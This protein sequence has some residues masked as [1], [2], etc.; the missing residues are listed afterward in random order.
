MKKIFSFFYLIALFPF[1]VFGQLH[2]VWQ[3]GKKNGSS[4]DFALAPNGYKEFVAE[5][6][7]Q[8]TIFNI[9]FSNPKKS[10]P[11]ILPGPSDDWAG[12][13]Y[14]SGYYPRH[15]SRIVFGLSDVP[16][17]NSTHLVLN[18]VDANEKTPPKVSISINGHKTSI[19]LEKGVGKAIYGNDKKGEPQTKEIEVPSKWLKK[20]LNTIEVGAIKG[21]W[22]VYDNIIFKS[23]KPLKLLP[24][25]NSLIYGVKL[26]DFESKEN[27]EYRQPILVDIYQLE[28][29][30][31]LTFKVNNQNI[32]SKKVEKGHS[33]IEIF[34]PATAKPNKKIDFQVF[35][36]TQLIYHKV[37]SQNPER[38]LKLYQYVDLLMGTGNSR[39]MFKPG[40]SLPLS[41]VQIAPDNQDEIWKGGYE[42]TVENIMGFSHFSD[43]TMCG[44]LTMPTGGKLQVN[45]G[46]EENPDAGYRSR[47]DKKT[48]SAKIG[49][50]SVYL[51][52]TKIKAEI[53]ST[54]R[55]SLQ[56]Y[57]FPKM[58]SARILVDLFTPSEYP[59]NLV[60]AKVLKTTNNEIVGEA[61]YYNAFTG[62]SLQQYYTI[63]FVM[64]FSKPF[65]NMGGWVNNSVEEVKNYIPYWDRKHVFNTDAEIFRQIDS[66]K[67]K[68]DLGV[69]LNFR[70]ENN[71][72]ILV[73]T[74]VSLVDVKGARN[75][76]QQEIITPFAWNFDAVVKNAENIW[77]EYLGRIQIETDDY[78]EKV[79][80]YTNMYRAL[81][82]K[83]IWNDEDGRYRD[84]NEVIKTLGDKHDNIISGEYWNTFWNNQQLFNLIA[85]EISSQWAKSA[86]TLYKNSGWFN[87]DPAGI[88]NT[89]VMVAMHVASQI[90]GAWQSG[91][92]DFELDTAY[93]GLKKMMTT[94]PQKYAGG[95]TVGV[96]N[97]MP[98]LKYD[99]IPSGM[100]EISNTMEYAYDDYS[101]S[102]MALSLG[103]NEDY[104]YF[105]NRSKNWTNIFDE[106]TGFARPKDENGKWISPFDP[107]H[108]PGFVEGNAFNYTWFVPHDPVGLIQK[109]GKQRFIS[110]L[111][112][113]MEKSALA[114]F[115]ASGDDFSSFPINHGNEPSM[116]VAYLFNWAGEPW[117][118]Q[119][120]VRAIQEKYYGTSPYDA[121]PGD[122]DLGQMSSWFVMSTLGLFQMDGGVSKNPTY[123]IGSP[124]YPK[125]T[126]NL[127]EKYGR[128]KQFIIE[129]KNASKENKYIKSAYLNGVKLEDFRIPQD[130]VLNG[131]YLILE[132]TSQPVKTNF[133]P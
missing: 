133:K 58:D 84:E 11:F 121:Y 27:K 128:E 70:T 62:Y 119:K 113:A 109:M 19:Q 24:A 5:F 51:T 55:A 60:N 100:G 103:K 80:F 89:G 115:N 131:G 3:I 112:N 48:E 65:K 29:T 52:D 95:G 83:A 17:K 98:Y 32:S 13:G 37:L 15:F 7:G 16:A 14:W 26:A 42:Y 40:P 21:S 2:T 56:R 122:E 23:L 54:R 101:L 4:N 74:G 33:I 35:E 6:G 8:K 22:A 20:G 45:P 124:R 69:F 76:L 43:W 86:I 53:T 118:T 117:L 99:Y 126:I 1:T 108:T 59:H 92:R 44:L 97:L 28:K 39:W 71:E 73:R 123:E 91:I 57:T 94:P 105:L 12:G 36:N 110:V 67:G 125:M 102:Q 78:L 31:N 88:E 104:K 111:N 68:G 63:Y 75:N 77:D 87:T 50:Y 90:E 25:F 132:M 41:M 106:K 10:W 61:T 127:G 49:K 79:K 9:G 18:F 81:A 130:K 120:W 82:A 116:Q 114:N 64:Q 66:I 96:E 85:P 38:E 72:Q 129:A 34:L 30:T 47:I 107:Y 46:T 93:A